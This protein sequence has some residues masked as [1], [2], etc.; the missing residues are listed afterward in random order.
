MGKA[1]Y[2][3]NRILIFFARCLVIF[4]KRSVFDQLNSNLEQPCRSVEN[5][6]PFLV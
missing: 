6:R 2:C 4:E 5:L 3:S 1:S